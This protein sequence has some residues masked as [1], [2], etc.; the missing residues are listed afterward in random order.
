MQIYIVNKSN[1]LIFS[2]N[3]VDVPNSM[4]IILQFWILHHIG[5]H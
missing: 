5:K 2:K 4:Q 3:T 1:I